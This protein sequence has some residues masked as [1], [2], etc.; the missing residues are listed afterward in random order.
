[1][2]LKDIL[3]EFP[4][5]EKIG[6][7]RFIL[8]DVKMDPNDSL[9]LIG[10]FNDQLH[11]DAGNR[12][13]DNVTKD[14]ILSFG[15]FALAVMPPEDATFFKMA[16]KNLKLN[17]AY[18]KA[19]IECIWKQL[20]VYLRTESIGFDDKRQKLYNLASQMMEQKS[21]EQLVAYLTPFDYEEHRWVY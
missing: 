7:R 19:D 15:S 9:S 10:P 13:I 14:R 1:M 20:R 8:L 12:L 2:K 3:D 4:V 6:A 18:S 21:V 5:N 11:V 16:D 17:V